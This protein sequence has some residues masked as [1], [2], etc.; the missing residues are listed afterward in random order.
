MGRLF[1]LAREDFK[2]DPE[3][4]RELI[5][6]GQA[7][8]SSGLDAAEHATWTTVARAILNL[9]ETYTRN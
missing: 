4:A 1:L 5:S 3:A 6:T 7:P 9:S 8:M 2:A